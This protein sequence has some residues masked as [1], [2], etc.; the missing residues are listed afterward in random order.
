MKIPY[1][2]IFKWFIYIS[3]G[4][5]CFLYLIVFLLYFP[6]GSSMSPPLVTS[7]RVNIA[8]HSYYKENGK[9]PVNQDHK[10]GGE[11]LNKDSTLFIHEKFSQEEYLQVFDLLTEKDGLCNGKP[12]YKR[13]KN[14]HS[15]VVCVRSNK[16][17]AIN[18][19][20]KNIEGVNTFE[21]FKSLINTYILKEKIK[22]PKG[23][24]GYC[25]VHH[26]LN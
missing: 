20:L 26:R 17:I 25:E 12:W 11:C 15:F 9:Y 1:K 8:A 4:L 18:M 23:F 24:H 10:F 7:L 2:K 19:N 16:K 22:I 5:F 13:L 21:D 6:W 14:E 3:G